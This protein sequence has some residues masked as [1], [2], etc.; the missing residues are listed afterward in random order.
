MMRAVS[1]YIVFAVVFLAGL[2]VGAVRHARARE[3]VR[4]GRPVAV[5]AKRV[6]IDFM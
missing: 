2:V 4:R 3:A 6:H 5:R 1:L